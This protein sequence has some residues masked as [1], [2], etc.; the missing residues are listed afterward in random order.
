MNRKNNMDLKSNYEGNNFSFRKYW[1]HTGATSNIPNLDMDHAYLN[2][3][4]IYTLDTAEYDTKTDKYY[5][6]FRLR[7]DIFGKYFSENK[8][9]LPDHNSYVYDTMIETGDFSQDPLDYEGEAYDKFMDSQNIC[10]CPS[11]RLY[12]TQF[13]S[14]KHFEYNIRYDDGYKLPNEPEVNGGIEIHLKLKKTFQP[15]KTDD[16]KIIVQRDNFEDNYEIPVIIEGKRDYFDKL[17]LVY[18]WKRWDCTKK[19]WGKKQLY[20]M[21]TSLKNRKK[22]DNKTIFYLT[23]RNYCPAGLRKYYESMGFKAIYRYDYDETGKELRCGD[24]KVSAIYMECTVKD[25]LKNC[26]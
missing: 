12:E 17:E 9:I 18:F 25:F 13:C 7:K 24:D 5:M 1:K 16:G 4:D 21:I 14:G 3:G 11:N 2:N 6:N 8:L 22:I 15:C 26:F 23:T 19:G 10:N 20:H